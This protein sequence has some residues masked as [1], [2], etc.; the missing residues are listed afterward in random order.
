MLPLVGQSDDYSKY[1]AS[2][3]DVKH[4]AEVKE[5]QFPIDCQKAYEMG[6]RL[7]KNMRETPLGN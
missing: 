6:E 1:E 7:V 5:K 3:F 4:K 2:M